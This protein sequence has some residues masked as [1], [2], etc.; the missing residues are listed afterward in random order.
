MRVVRK[1]LSFF[2][3]VLDPRTYL[4]VLRLLHYYNYSHVREK[5]KL[6]RGS[7]VGFPPNISIANGERIA[8]GARSRIGA[9]SSLWAGDSHGRIIIGEDCRLGPDCFLTA[10]DYGAQP[11]LKIF[12][13]PRL[14]ADIV[15]GNDVW[16][17]ARVFVTAGVEI[18]DGCVVGAGAVVTRSLP[19]GAVAVGVPAHIVRNRADTPAGAGSSGAG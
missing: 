9:R 3:S 13:Q 12:E 18:G 1:L 19:P 4:H 7:G 17:G 16:L 5:R 15:L 6:T 8:I 10:S 11:G 14:E 2:Y